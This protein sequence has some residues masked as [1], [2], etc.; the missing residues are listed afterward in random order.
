[1]SRFKSIL[2]VI[3][4]FTMALPVFAQTPEIKGS[5]YRGFFYSLTRNYQATT[6]AAISFEDSPR[7]ER[8]IR[9][10]RIYLSLRDAIALALENNLDIEVARLNPKLQQSNLQRASA[11]QLLRNVSN[12]ISLSL[13]H[14]SEPTRRT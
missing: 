1:M 7:I 12:S 6:V 4:C 5:S 14:I 11:G 3:L 13:I 2:S 9:A 10:G 8:L